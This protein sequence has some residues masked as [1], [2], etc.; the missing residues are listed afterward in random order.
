[1]LQRPKG[2]R[3]FLPEEME[4]RRAIE[5]RLREHA[6][7]W[8]YREISTP[9]F[10]LLDLFTVKSGEGI[11]NEVYAFEDKKG[12]AMAL[13]PEIT[14]PVLRMYVNEARSLP[15]PLRWFYFS[16][17][18]RYEDPQKG[19]YRQFWQFG[20]ELIGVDSPEA[21]AEVILLADD[22]LRATGVEFTL[23]VGHL[24]PMKKVLSSL[25]P[26][27]Q[28]RLMRFLDKRD[29]EGMEKFLGE[30]LPGTGGGAGIPGLQAVFNTLKDLTAVRHLEELWGLIG[31]I[32]ERPR[33]EALDAILRKEGLSFTWNFAIARGLDYYTGMVFEGF[34]EHLGAENQILGGGEY[35]L[36][37]LFGGDDVP[38]SGFAIGFDR[39]MV[40]L[41]NVKEI[42]VERWPVVMVIPRGKGKEQAFATARAFRNAWSREMQLHDVPDAGGKK[43]IAILDLTDQNIGKKMSHAAKIADFA[44]IVGDREVDAGMVSLKDLHTSDQIEMKLE[45]A[46]I[47]VMN[48]VPR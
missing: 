44:V 18:F 37:K 4:E 35:R 47:R 36:A 29:F 13:R 38:S 28:S 3:D 11:I 2:T 31:D 24:A 43:I 32:P 7:S 33:I 6:R 26:G 25:D 12:L 16:D 15:K 34:A 1:M 23:Q 8:G 41:R 42:P 14:A 19:R 10:E 17:C 40:S 30:Q 20:T 21:D 46:V 9:A 5:G 27:V 48:S 45:D 22:L 39:V